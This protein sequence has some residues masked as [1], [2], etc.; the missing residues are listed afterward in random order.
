VTGISARS[1]VDCD[2]DTRFEWSNRERLLSPVQATCAL[3]L[4]VK[5]LPRQL[6]QAPDIPSRTFW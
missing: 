1:L 6:S 3:Q 2:P 4:T 5:A